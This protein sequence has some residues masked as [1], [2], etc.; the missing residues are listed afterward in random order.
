MYSLL[1]LDSLAGAMQMVC[2]F[3]TVVAALMSILTLRG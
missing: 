2:Y 1:P 3:F